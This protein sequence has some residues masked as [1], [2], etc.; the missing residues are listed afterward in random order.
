[1]FSSASGFTADA[2]AAA[3]KSPKTQAASKK[4]TLEIQKKEAM[5]IVH[6]KDKNRAIYSCCMM[7]LT[8]RCLS[9]ISP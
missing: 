8:I 9:A 6:S 4:N 3:Q 7:G 1:M 2:A 5:D